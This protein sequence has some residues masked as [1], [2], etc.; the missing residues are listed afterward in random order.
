MVRIDKRQSTMLRTSSTRM[1]R[2]LLANGFIIFPSNLFATSLSM[3][4]EDD[5]DVADAMKNEHIHRVFGFN[6]W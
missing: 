3:K 1:R 2:E 4:H 5:D 6:L